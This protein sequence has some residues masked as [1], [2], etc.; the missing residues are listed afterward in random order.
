MNTSVLWWV[1]T[2]RWRWWVWKSSLNLLIF[3]KCIRA[4][5]NEKYEKRMT[6]FLQDWQGLL[7]SA[8]TSILL[9]V[10]L[11]K[12]WHCSSE[13]N[14][15]LSQLPLQLGT[16]WRPMTCNEKCG[17]R[18]YFLA[19]LVSHRSFC[20][21]FLS[22]MMSWLSRASADRLCGPGGSDRPRRAEQKGGNVC[23]GHHGTLIQSLLS[24]TG[25]QTASVCH[26]Y[27]DIIYSID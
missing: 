26:S 7:I 20:V 16:V 22:L 24:L 18:G 1:E 17:R 8:L 15:T 9:V 2:G 10:F 12:S 23:Q 5:V 4:L 11:L 3:L 19:D 21:A 13:S 6:V 25:K 14:R 27:F